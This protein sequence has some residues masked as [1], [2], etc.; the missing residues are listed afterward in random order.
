MKEPI[1]IKC[2]NVIVRRNEHY[3]WGV[4]DL[5]GNIIVPYGKY[6][7]IDGFDHGL[8]RV[9]SSGRLVYSNSLRAIITSN[10][11]V[12]GNEDC[13]SYNAVQSD[14]KPELYCKWG[15]INKNGEEVLPLEYEEIWN[16]YGH[17]RET[18]IVKMNGI[19]S[20]IRFKDFEIRDIK[21]S[22]FDYY[23]EKEDDSILQLLYYD[24]SNGKQNEDMASERLSTFLASLDHMQVQE[25]LESPI[26]D[27]GD[28]VTLFSLYDKQN[29]REERE[30]EIEL[31]RILY[32]LEFNKDEVYDPQAWAD[33]LKNDWMP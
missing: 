31:K 26:I 23:C 16:F 1:E 28:Y 2:G 4:I 7:W 6:A 15:L 22:C 14:L 11:V 27:Y 9:R 21:K 5:D 32:E 30:R 3:Q 13:N 10:R 29:E 19:V 20:E 25:P 18:T 33:E 12:V 24:S 8:A 17:N